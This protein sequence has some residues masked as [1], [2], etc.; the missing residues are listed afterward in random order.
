MPIYNDNRLFLTYPECRETIIDGFIAKMAQ[1]N[2]SFD[3]I[4]GVATAGIGPG[5][6]LSQ[7]LRLPFFYVRDKPKDHGME[8]RIEG[9]QP[10]RLVD[11][12]V[13]TIEDLVSTGGSS[14]GAVKA[15]RG[16][17]AKANYCFSIFNYG[18]EETR[19]L[20]DEMNPPC[21]LDSLLTYDVLLDVASE[22]NYI[23]SE[24]RDMLAEWRES[25]FTWGEKHGFPRV[26][27]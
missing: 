8:N 17:G 14:V 21:I 1:H 15:I 12:D 11:R 7:R 4:A 5:A 22:Y 20:F 19:K 23:Q 10:E 25:P 13:L 27:A 24:Q 3:I 18:F 16:A 2:K 6:I 9:I 26:V